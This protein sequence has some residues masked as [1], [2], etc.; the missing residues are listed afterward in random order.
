MDAHMLPG[1]RHQVEFITIF[2]VVRYRCYSTSD[3]T[4]ASITTREIRSCHAEK[5][6]AEKR[7]RSPDR[8]EERIGVKLSDGSIYALEPDNKTIRMHE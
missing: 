2:L 5:D 8:L 7:T 3:Y 6:E 4:D 1:N